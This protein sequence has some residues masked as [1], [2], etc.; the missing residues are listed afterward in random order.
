M[1]ATTCSTISQKMIRATS[2]TEV[3]DSAATIS[4]TIRLIQK[5][6]PLLVR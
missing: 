3:S 2:L 5:I 6:A 4:I 1:N